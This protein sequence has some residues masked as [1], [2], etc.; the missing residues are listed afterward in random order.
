M[1]PR[2]TPIDFPGGSG[3]VPTGA[4]QFRDDWPGLFIR[5]DD[6]TSLM[7]NI[8]AMAERLKNVEDVTVC[9]ALIKLVHIAEL[10]DR[11]VIVRS[12]DTP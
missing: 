7:V 12:D 5:G 1:E 9:S 10:I 4:I 8:Y 3:R 2:I 6:A 11:D